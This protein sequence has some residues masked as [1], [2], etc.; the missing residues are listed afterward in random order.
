MMIMSLLQMSVS[1]TIFIAAVVSIRAL[2]INMLP[3]KTFLI[4][5]EVVLLRL[6]IPFSVPSMLSVYSLIGRNASGD[7]FNIIQPDNIIPLLQGKAF[8]LPEELSWAGGGIL[9][10]EKLLT[11]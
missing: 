5:W 1:G 11:R 6:L 7:T 9:L 2:A 8:E 10:W 3:K 4:L